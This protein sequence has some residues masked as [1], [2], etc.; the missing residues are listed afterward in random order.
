[1]L[2]YLLLSVKNLWGIMSSVNTNMTNQVIS[3]NTFPELVVRDERYLL[4]NRF[5][6][7]HVRCYLINMRQYKDTK[8]NY[9]WQYFIEIK[10][11]NLRSG[12]LT[13]L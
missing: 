3:V 11:D 1:M 9:K 10:S 6:D 2:Y 8:S 5:F 12:E 7:I 13:G 4:R